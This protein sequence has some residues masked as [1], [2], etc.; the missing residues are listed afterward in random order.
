MEHAAAAAENRPLTSIRGVAAMWVVYHHWLADAAL[1]SWAAT[2]LSA[3]YSA[4]D[5]FFILSGLILSGAYAGLTLPHVPLFFLRRICRVYPL[6]WLTLAALVMLVTW[7]APLAVIRGHVWLTLACSALL[8]HP[9][10]PIAPLANPPS[11]STGIELACYLGFPCA[12]A[13]LRGVRRR[14]T[15]ASLVALLVAAEWVVTGRYSGDTAGIGALARGVAGFG[16]GMV[17]WAAGRRIVMLPPWQ[18]TLCEGMGAGGILVGA[19]SGWPQLV[20]PASALLLFALSFDA[21][22]VARLLRGRWWVWLGHIS[23]SIYLVHYPLAVAADRLLGPAGPGAIPRTVGMTAV[24]LLLS[25]ATWRFVEEPGRR[26][27]RLLL[28]RQGTSGRHR[29][30]VSEPAA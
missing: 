30:A 13:M 18:A 20:P 7:P 1:P 28:A 16:L 12:L 27:P 10:L 9:F 6:H 17:L 11:W 22:I 15:I 25:T 2:A 21:G 3:G 14:M 5:L 26:L 23:F 8:I 24:L 29:A 4:V 19:M